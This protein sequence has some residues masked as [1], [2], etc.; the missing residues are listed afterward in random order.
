M[1]VKAV[2]VHLKFIDPFEEKMAYSISCFSEE[3]TFYDCIQRKFLV[4]QPFEH[5]E[6]AFYTYLLT[7]DSD[8]WIGYV[9]FF[10]PTLITA[11]YHFAYQETLALLNKFCTYFK[12]KN[13][14]LLFDKLK[15]LLIVEKDSTHI[16][17]LLEKTITELKNLIVIDCDKK[18]KM[19]STYY[20]RLNNFLENFPKYYY[21][22]VVISLPLEEQFSLE[23]E[24][25]ETRLSCDLLAE[26]KYYGFIQEVL[27]IVE[28]EIEK[29]FNNT[30]ILVKK[31]DEIISVNT[32][33]I[34]DNTSLVKKIK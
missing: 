7:G 26:R 21:L 23:K 1:E 6:Y 11:Y 33:T 17:I 22:D 8:E 29:N 28:K 2:M 15:R 25:K 13:N 32:K 31:D 5:L 3:R 14:Y 19:F 24:N 18:E 12:T 10:N 16:S 30:T 20:H 27:S 9:Q 34:L 4:D